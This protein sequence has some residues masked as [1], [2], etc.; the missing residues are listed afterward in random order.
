MKR[1]TMDKG[2]AIRTI[3]LIV[4]LVNQFLVAFGLSPFP[5]SAQEIEVAL[6]YVFT[7]LATLWTWW[8]NNDLTPEAYEGT[9][10][11]RELKRKKGDK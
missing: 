11:T 7:V 5:F 9:K 1:F 10:L 6:S 4:A 3:V 8:K 2:T